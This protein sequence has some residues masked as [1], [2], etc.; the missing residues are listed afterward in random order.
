MT[1]VRE[2]SVER[3][4][5]G[6]ATDDEVEAVFGDPA[7]TLRLEEVAEDDETFHMLYE[8]DEQ[9]EAIARR[10]HLAETRDA[11]ARRKRMMGGGAALLVPVMALVGV[12]ALR[13]E[14]DISEPEPLT[15]RAKGLRPSLVVHR[16][17][18]DGEEVLAGHD[19]AREG[20]VLQLAYVAGDALHGVV[21]SI[22]G[23]GSVTLHHPP[24]IGGDTRLDRGG[25]ARLPHGYQLDDAPNFERFFFVTDDE[26]ID[27]EAVLGQADVLVSSDQ[28]LHGPL[29]L[30]GL[31]VD[32]FVVRKATR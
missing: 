3:V 18:D 11:V 6:E 22:D 5:L 20:D 26:P 1:K 24:S 25:E 27:V 7:A 12:F 10:L 31:R 9:L 16:Q 30:E 28:G 15:Q 29:E 8:K 23:G 14:V 19:V 4:H 2:F 17:V 32:D 21:V 13:P